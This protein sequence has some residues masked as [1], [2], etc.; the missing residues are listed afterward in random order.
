[1]NE[2]SRENFQKLYDKYDRIAR[3]IIIVLVFLFIAQL[4]LGLWN[5]N[6]AHD[7]TIRVKEIQASRKNSILIS[8]EEQN[9]R[10][11]NSISTLNNLLSKKL[12]VSK[13][14]LMQIEQTKNFTILLINALAPKQNCAQRVEKFTR[15]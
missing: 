13:E 1:M 10:N 7:N 5:L 15:P 8:C 14:K 2:T 9:S 11:E 4:G 12:I 6:L 3:N